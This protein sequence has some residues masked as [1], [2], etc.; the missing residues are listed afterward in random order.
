MP[1]RRLSKS[2]AIQLSLGIALVTA[3]L[4]GLRGFGYEH[5]GF[6]PRAIGLGPRPPADPPFHVS[7]DALISE[8]FHSSDPNCH[9][10]AREKLPG[11]LVQGVVVGLV[12]LAVLV[13]LARSGWDR[14]I[15]PAVPDGSSQ[16]AAQLERL[17]LLR[18]SGDLSDE[19]FAAAKRSLLG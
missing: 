8:I 15:E 19:E 5:S 12:A 4:L 11:L 14:A 10:I 6:R 18:Q 1:I 2:Q 7:C 9:F 13:G 3:V 16:M 17:A